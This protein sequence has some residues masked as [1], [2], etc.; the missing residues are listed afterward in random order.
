MK[1]LFSF[2]LI[3]SITACTWV[4]DEE[5]ECPYGFWLNLHY[6]Y[7]ILDVDAAPEFIKEAS[8]YVYDSVG[9]YVTRIDASQAELKANNQ[10]IRIKGIPEGDYQFVVWGGINSNQYTVAGSNNTMSQFRLSLAEQDKACSSEL[11]DLYY[12]YKRLHFKDLYAEHDVYLV[13][14]TNQLASIIA[15]IARG[16]EMNPEDFTL[17]MKTANGTMNIYNELVSDKIITYEPYIKEKVIVKD[18]VNGELHGIKLSIKTLRLMAD[19]DCRLIFENNTTGDQ[20]FNISYP[21]IVGMIGTLYTNMGRQLTT[22]EY[23]DRQDFHTLIFFLS[24]DMTQLV[25]VRCQLKVISWRDRNN[26]H[27]KL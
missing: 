21:E 8:V 16:V 3:L 2:I 20:I 22:Q 23:L 26:N 14:N 1:K 15:P 9:N 5:E 18:S 10:R 13:K 25:Q 6:T 11:T 17:R 24:E 4:K 19:T 27:L 12:G 7:N